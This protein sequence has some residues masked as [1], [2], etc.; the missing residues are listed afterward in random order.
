MTFKT[1]RGEQIN[2]RVASSFINLD[3]PLLNLRELG[4]NNLETIKEKGR[5]RWNDVLGRIEVEDSDIDH[6]RT[7]YSCLYRSVLF[8]RSFYEIDANGNPV[9]VETFNFGKHKG[10]KV[11]DVLRYDPGYYSWILSGEFTYNTKQVLTRIRLAEAQK[12]R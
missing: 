2:A 7:F 8:P 5:Q 4:N 9:L 6:L 3:Q 12:N 10:K 1:Q 11:A